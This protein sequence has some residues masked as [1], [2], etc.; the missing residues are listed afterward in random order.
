MNQQTIEMLTLIFAGEAALMMTIMCII[1]ITRTLKAR[2]KDQDAGNALAKEV[3][4]S[5]DERHAALKEAFSECYTMEDDE[6]MKVVDEFIARER[7]FY[8]TLIA[9][10]VNRDGEQFKNLTSSLNEVVDSYTDLAKTAEPVANSEALEALEQ[11]NEALSKELDESKDV[12]DG[13]MDEYKA[14]FDKTG[15]Q[16]A[17]DT[18]EPDDE[19]MEVESENTDEVEEEIALDDLDSDESEAAEDDIDLGEEDVPTLNEIA[20]PGSEDENLDDLDDLLAEATEESDEVDS[21]DELDLDDIDLGDVDE[22][23]SLEADDQADAEPET[24]DVET[25]AEVDDI[26]ALLEDINESN[27]SEA[28]TDEASSQAVLSDDDIDALLSGDG[29]DEITPDL[30]AEASPEEDVAIEDDVSSEESGEEV[31]SDPAMSMDEIDALLNGE[32]VGEIESEPAEASEMDE[33][34]TASSEVPEADEEDA[35]NDFDI[36][37]DA[38]MAESE[39]LAE[40]VAEENTATESEEDAM[41]SSMEAT[42]SDVDEAEAILDEMLSGLAESEASDESE[43]LEAEET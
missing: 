14:T 22:G 33:S 39:A 29:E 8:K 9:V 32:A 40:E 7:A 12:M 42:Q 1:M 15:E 41:A 38:I 20:D 23:E 36:D 30:M 35:L 6:L 18:E 10:Y 11:K 28:E 21:E 26:D 27:E 13:L 25:A 3:L 19:N 31:D 24:E 16:S 2:G 4:K 37:I 17:S 34:E 43:K 5:E